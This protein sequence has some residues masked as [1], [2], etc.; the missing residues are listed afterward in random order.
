MKKNF[1]NQE[2]E[3]I[4]NVTGEY[5]EYFDKNLDD[6]FSDRMIDVEWID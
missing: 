6:I 3:H 5:H 2:Q 4:D 1:N